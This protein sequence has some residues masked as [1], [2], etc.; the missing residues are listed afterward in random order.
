L[1]DFVFAFYT[2]PIFR[3]E[4]LLLGLL[5]HSPSSD[6]DAR[7]GENSAARRRE[8][9]AEAVT[10]Y[11]G[12]M[13]EH[14]YAQLPARFYS[15]VEPTRVAAPR[16]IHWNQPLAEHLQLDL[17]PKNVGRLAQIFSGN[18]FLPGSEPLAMVYAGQQF[19]HFVPQ[20]GDGRAIL[21]GEARDL[22]HRLH[23]IHLKG[24]GKT[25]YSR[26][27]DG[28]AALGP[29]LRECLVS[30]AMTALGVP[31]TRTLAAVLTGEN[32]FREGAVPGAVLTRTAAS[33]VR[34]GTFQ[35]FA[36]RGDTEAVRML[37]DYVIARHYPELRGADE[38]YLALLQR[39]V[40][41]QADLVARWLQVGFIHG[42]MNTDNTTVS[43]E[44]IDFG[45]CAFLDVYDPN[46]VFSSIDR[47]GRY[48][49]SN[50]APIAQWNMARFAETLLP[51]IDSNLDRAVAVATDAVNDFSPRFQEHWLAGMRLKLGLATAQAD[52]AALIEQWLAIMHRGSMDFT[53]AFRGL[54]ALV[55]S[56]SEAW[57]AHRESLDGAFIEWLGAWRA[58]GTAENFSPAER[59]E[60]MRRVNPKYIPR[61]HR[62]EQLIQAAVR[63]ADFSPFETLL[64]VVSRPFD[65]QPAAEGYAA[66]PTADERVLQTFC[67]T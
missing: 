36:A 56:P 53:Q 46:A 9:I 47:N 11:H 13:L 25:P 20:L 6:A 38:P 12:G 15:R 1:A 29:V 2:S 27:G 37:A 19:G 55:E 16:L 34:V 31:S 59:A 65:E 40:Q 22:N 35:Y 44:T 64:D 33:H 62:I 63:D 8:A 17:D 66:A 58:R 39:V 50:Q 4:R 32:V 7:A 30:E 43:G 51:L 60:S 28:R 14:T 3:V 23:D 41:R 48:A 57:D 42:V 45:P 10:W 26:G 52:D 54:C 18:E 5:A 61:N 21:L 24:A 67:G 49:Y